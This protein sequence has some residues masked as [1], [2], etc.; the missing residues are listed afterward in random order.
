MAGS[1]ASIRT[2]FWDI[3]GVLLTNG[4]GHSQRTRVLGRLGVDL[5]AYEGLHDRVNYYWERGLIDAEE[6]FLQTVLR[7]NP[8]LGLT[9]DMLWPQV[10][11]ESRVIHPECLDILAEMKSSGR[12]RLATL[13]NE[14]RELNEYRL[15][16]FKLRSLFDYFICSGY[17]HEMKPKPPIYEAAIDISGFPAHTALLIDDKPENCE[18]AEQLGLHAICFETPSRLRESLQNY[19]I[20]VH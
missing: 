20:E 17:I 2:V 18:A 5:A 19:G 6:F 1:S 10:C 7:P 14:S 13:N 15:D 11:A 16:N 8:M 3:G 12:W 9:F 4:W